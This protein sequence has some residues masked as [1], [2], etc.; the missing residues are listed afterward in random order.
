VFQFP[1]H[2]EPS[3]YVAMLVEVDAAGVDV[4][5]QPLDRTTADGLDRK[6]IRAPRRA[7]IESVHTVHS[8]DRDGKPVASDL[9]RVLLDCWERDSRCVGL[10]IRAA[11]SRPFSIVANGRRVLQAPS[12]SSALLDSHRL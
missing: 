5:V 10:K 7:R 8:P 9:N 12:T 1:A 11:R 4:P 2:W 6:V 3:D